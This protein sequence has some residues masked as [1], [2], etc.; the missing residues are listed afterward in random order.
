V[1]RVPGKIVGAGIGILAVILIVIGSIYFV[2]EGRLNQVYEIQVETLEIPTDP[3]SIQRGEHLVKVLAGCVDCHGEDLSG[4]LFFDDPLSGSIASKNLTSGKGG[5]G[6]TY[7]DADWVRTIRHGVGPNGK[8]LVEIPSNIFYNISD[9]D[10]GAMVAYL[11]S[12]PPVD[13]ELP[14]DTVGPLTRVFILLEPSLL[15]AQVIDHQAPRPPTPAEGVTA[16]Y[17]RY[18]A[19]A[20][21][22]C[23]GENLSG[24]LGAGSGL[25]LTS[26]GEL[27]SWSVDEFI[28]TLRSGVTPSG[29]TLDPTLMPWKRI[30]KLTDDELKAIWL[31]LKT[32]PSV[33]SQGN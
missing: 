7:S 3:E 13:N 19:V 30:G 20:C 17:G 10:L 26:G 31:F 15:P 32:I 6:S 33:E 2:V 23:H 24:G 22:V 5:V 14:A 29:R 28:N 4:M 1:I 8:P 27:A 11:K 25:N 16:E 18:L 12:I 21:T 9:D